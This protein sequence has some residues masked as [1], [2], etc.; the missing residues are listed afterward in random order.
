MDRYLIIVSGTELEGPFDSEE[1]RAE[2]A[3]DHEG[4][5]LR[6]IEL[7]LPQD[8]SGPRVSDLWDFET[9]DEPDD[10]ED[11]DAEEEENEEAE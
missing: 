10:L 6:F 11:S 5:V 3:R 4:V 7:D 1:H 8:G 2:A 9:F